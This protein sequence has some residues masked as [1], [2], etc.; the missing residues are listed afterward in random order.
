VDEILITDSDWPSVDIEKG[1]FEDSGYR[2]RLARC[3]TEADVIAEGQGAVALLDQ[4][5]PI[6]E[7]VMEALPAVRVVGRYGVS[8][9][10]IDLPAAERH[11]IRVVNVPDYCVGEVADHALGLVLA[12]TRGI[13]ALDPGS[14]LGRGTIGWAA[15]C[16]DPRRCSWGWSGS[17]R[18][19]LRWPVA[20]WPW[21]S[22]WSRPTR[23]DPWSKGSGW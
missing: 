6:S 15:G 9:D 4:Y 10:T 18:S 21:A 16:S 8:L 22:G 14:V 3:R 19:A 12:L 17:E 20:H 5:A 1:I 7:A 11:G 2:V 23:D 13:V